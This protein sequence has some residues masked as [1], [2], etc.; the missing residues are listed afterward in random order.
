MITL[1]VGS[2]LVGAAS[3]CLTALLRPPGR[4]AYCLG[5]AVVATAEVVA[6]SHALS[7]VDAYERSWFL[8]ASALA[9][10]AAVVAIALVRPPWPSLDLRAVA[11]ELLRDRL[12]TVLAAVVAAEFLYLLAL[13]LFTPP[14]ERDALAYHITRALLWIQQGAVEPTNDAADTRIDELP[15]NS[16]ILEGVTMLLSGSVRWVGLVQLAALP[17]AVLA[18]YGMSTRI[19][20]TRRQAGFGAL[21][22]PTL[23]VVALQ[24]PTALNDLLVAA[25]IAVAAFFALG[26]SWADLVLA[27]L[28][29][30]VLVGTKGTGLFALPVLLLLALYAHRGRRLVVALAIGVLAIAIGSGWYIV[31]LTAGKGVLGEAGGSVGALDGPVAIAAR[32]TRYVLHAFELPGSQ[33]KDK[34]LYVAL[35]G[36]ILAIGLVT[37]RQRDAAIA[38]AL[39]GLALLV[40]PLEALLHRVYWNGWEAVGYPEAADLEPVRD[41]T[42]ASNVQSWFGPVGLALIVAGLVL[43]VHGWRR[44]RL[45]WVA[46]VLTAAPALFVVESAVA[47]GYHGLNGRYVMGCA[48]LSASVWGLA[49]QWTSASVAIV[50]VA[51]TTV[52]TSLVNYTER[53]SGLD[54]VEG[55]DRQSIWRLPREWAQSIEPEVA[56]LIGYADDHVP[57]AAPIAL[58]RSAPYPTAFAGYP[59]IEHRILY[60]NTL[61]E[62]RRRNVDWV[63]LPQPTRCEDGW[64]VVFRSPP[65]AV[66]RQVPGTRC[67]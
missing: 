4:V 26:R 8:A 52:T 65:W 55:S 43:A 40:L 44:G 5:V 3:V 15:P 6:I 18:V 33:G 21:L 59:R 42:L 66:Y 22:V 60:A 36:L 61:A 35:A 34:L 58:A 23:P 16:E 41:S 13:A 14:V 20:L 56:R 51:A 9:A 30:A 62:A 54:L 17:A 38:A 48:L 46:I 57:D 47:V 1:L 10:A 28:T 25:L 31:N 29:L 12:V 50:A 32:T 45:P 67:R 39:T 49:R 53:P 27:G 11:R 64:R 63:V 7:F 2:S 19:G 24:A 37:R